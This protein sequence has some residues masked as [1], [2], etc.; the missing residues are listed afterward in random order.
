MNQKKIIRFIIA[1]VVLLVGGTT[2]VK[3]LN[4]DT[5]DSNGSSQPRSANSRRTAGTGRGTTASANAPTKALAESVLTPTVRTQLKYTITWNGTGSFA[6]NNNKSTLNANVSSAPYAT[7]KP[8][9]SLGRPHQFDGLLS[10]STRIYQNR[11]ETG[12]DKTM[13]PVGWNQIQLSGGGYSHLYDRGH[14]GGYALVGGIRSF[15]ASEANPKNIATQTAWANEAAGVDNTG[16]NY[17]EGIVRKAL[18]QNKRVRYRV[19]DIYDGNNLVPAGANIQ[20][21]SSDGSVNFNVF[22]PNVQNGVVIN[23]KTGVA[24][25]K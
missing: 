1:A 5:S 19:I 24:K 6:I 10:K 13:R 22:V 8:Q 14:L 17:Y 18:D 23:Y 11:T 15:D 16:Q 7:N 3:S 21:K 12:N 9:D 20:A 4:H 25:I 2:G